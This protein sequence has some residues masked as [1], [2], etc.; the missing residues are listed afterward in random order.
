LPDIDIDFPD[1]KRDKVIKNLKKKYGDDKVMCLATIS[2]LQP[3][4]AIGEFAKAL[5]IPPYETDEVKNAIIERSSGDAR[6]AMCLQD[7][8]E[9]TDAGKA[10]LEK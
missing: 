5:G 8:F 9:T 1:K 6:A 3:R 4:S 10:F 7:T 2:R